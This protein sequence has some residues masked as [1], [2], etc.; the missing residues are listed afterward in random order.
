MDPVVMAGVDLAPGIDDGD[1]G[2]AYPV[3]RA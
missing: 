1:D 2:F 3:F